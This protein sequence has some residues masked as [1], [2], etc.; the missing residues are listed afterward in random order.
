MSKRFQT[1]MARPVALTLSEQSGF[2][3]TS[4]YQQQVMGLGPTFDRPRLNSVRAMLRRR[5]SAA[6]AQFEERTWRAFW[7]IAIEE[8]HAVRG[9][10]GAGLSPDGVRQARSRVL[11]RLEEEPGEPIA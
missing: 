7:R 1:R 2:G 11:R 5:P 10:H 9:R 8:R 6:R 3:L 4:G